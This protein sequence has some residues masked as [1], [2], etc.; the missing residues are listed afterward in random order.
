[1]LI[2]LFEPNSS[3]LGFSSSSKS[4]KRKADEVSRENEGVGGWIYVGSHNFSPS[5]WVSFLRKIW[6]LTD[7]ALSISRTRPLR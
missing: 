6:K 3:S 5:A 4:G 2:A 1:M 7:R